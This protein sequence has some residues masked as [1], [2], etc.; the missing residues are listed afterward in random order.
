MGNRNRIDMKDNLK[1]A[2]IMEKESCN[3]QMGTNMMDNGLS[4]KK[5]EKECINGLMAIIMTDTGKKILPRV[6]EL[7]VLVVCFMMVN[8]I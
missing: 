7:L 5:K 3:M 2:I 1:T 6:L 8:F 4:V